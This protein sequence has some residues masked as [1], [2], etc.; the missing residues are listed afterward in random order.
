MHKIKEMCIFTCIK[1][2]CLFNKYCT[3]Y[4]YLCKNNEH[5]TFFCFCFYHFIKFFVLENHVKTG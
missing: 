4:L 5:L 1:Q 2:T 3:K